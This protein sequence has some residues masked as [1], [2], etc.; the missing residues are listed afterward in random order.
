MALFGNTIMVLAKK[1]SQNPWLE[2]LV[3][4][5]PFDANGNDF[6]G[7]GNNGVAGGALPIF[8]SNTNINGEVVFQN[9]ASYFTIPD[10][11]SFTFSDGLQDLPFTF[12]GW[13]YFRQ[14]SVFGN[15]LLD[16]R[17]TVT[18]GEWLFALDTNRTLYFR[19]YADNNATLTTVTSVAIPL[20][21]WQHITYTDDGLGNLNSGKFYI[22]GGLVGSNNSGSGTFTKMQNTT[23]FVRVANISSGLS[24]GAQHLGSMDDFYIYKNRQLT[25]TEIQEVYNLGLNGQTLI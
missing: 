16:R 24:V 2:G 22:N 13:L 19:K 15:V 5:Y 11:D 17:T 1:K 14:V 12:M 23:H 21:I 6:S 7:N 10:S 3:A 18:S 25:A 20:N 8:G 4:Y 9:N